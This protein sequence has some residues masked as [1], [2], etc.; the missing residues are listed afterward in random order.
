ME[1]FLQITFFSGL[2]SQN[3]VENSL[4]MMKERVKGSG[5]AICVD[6]F[7]Q[8]GFAFTT[9]RMAWAYIQGEML[10]YGL[11]PGEHFTE[12]L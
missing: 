7:G 6:K 1:L 12:N 4:E 10:H 8:P 3:A 5:G 11:N 9:E 2:K